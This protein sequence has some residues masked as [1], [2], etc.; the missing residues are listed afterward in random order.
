MPNYRR[1]RIVGATYFF[2]VTLADRR[3]RILVKE[4]ALLRRIYGEA[5][6]RM[7]FKTV[8]ICVLPDHLHVVWELPED[9][10]DY[11]LRWALI[12]SQF[13]RAL[14]AVASVNASNI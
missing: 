10:R 6:K 2:T 7:P 13:S 3:S 5:N 11:S 14:P 9:D 12:K 8:A 4:I 1:E